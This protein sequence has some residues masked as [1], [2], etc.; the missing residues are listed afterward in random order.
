[1][2]SHR[3]LSG[4]ILLGVFSSFPRA[5][6]E[7]KR[8]GSRIARSKESTIHCSL[9]PLLS[10]VCCRPVGVDCFV[11]KTKK[12]KDL[13]I[14][15][16]EKTIAQRGHR[17]KRKGLLALLDVHRLMAA[18]RLSFW[19]TFEHP[20]RGEHH[21]SCGAP[22]RCIVCMYV[23]L[24]VCMYVCMYGTTDHSSNHRGEHVSITRRPPMSV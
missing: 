3:H 1:M 9:S 18:N 14:R 11:T 6:K 21:I 15:A 22:G 13:D 16:W 17:A 12:R 2:H 4:G 7:T 10:L 23:F 19:A 8:A 24:Y 5:S 20:G